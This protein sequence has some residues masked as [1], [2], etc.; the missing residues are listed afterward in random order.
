MADKQLIDKT[1]KTAALYFQKV[2]DEK[3]YDLWRAFGD[4]GFLHNLR[5]DVFHFDTLRR[6]GDTTN[7]CANKQSQHA[8]QG[9]RRIAFHGR[10]PPFVIC[11]YSLERSE[12]QVRSAFLTT[13]L[14]LFTSLS[15]VSARLSRA[16]H[17][18]ALMTKGYY[19]D[20]VTFSSEGV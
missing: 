11:I 6:E 14:L 19:F 9:Q 16:L 15:N 1:R 4:G 7:H 13:I 8:Q 17:I 12:T 5:D 18:N 10:G 3:P 20:N 2:A